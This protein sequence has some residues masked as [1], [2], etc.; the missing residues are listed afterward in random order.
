MYMKNRL[1][2]RA[3]FLIVL[4]AKRC[5]SEAVFHWGRPDFRNDLIKYQI[6]AVVSPRFLRYF[7]HPVALNFSSRRIEIVG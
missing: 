7:N 5:L 3:H 6:I 4:H 2:C 1:R